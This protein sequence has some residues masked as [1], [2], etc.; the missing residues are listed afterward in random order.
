M[1]SGKR[2]LRT[3]ARNDPMRTF[4][5]LL[6]SIGTP[7]SCGRCLIH[8]T[9]TNNENVKFMSGILFWDTSSIRYAMP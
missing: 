3:F 8:D 4:R 9:V 6:D 5:N 1:L 2:K 7:F